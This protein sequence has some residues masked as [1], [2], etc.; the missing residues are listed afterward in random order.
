MTWSPSQQGRQFTVSVPSLGEDVLLF[1]KMTA[2][3]EL[4][5]LFKYE[6]E[7][8]SEDHDITLKEVLG[9]KITIKV[10][11]LDGEF[12]FFSGHV[13]RFTYAGTRGEYARYLTTV[14]PWLWFLTL[15]SDCRIYQGE[16]VPDI[17]KD[18]FKRHGFADYEDGLDTGK[19]RKWDYCVQY[20]ETDFDFV[21]RLME[22]EGIY[23]YFKH[24]ETRHTLVLCDGVSD[25]DVTEGYEDI[26]YHPEAD[27]RESVEYIARWSVSQQVA[28]VGIG[29]RDFDFRKPR[30]SMETTVPTFDD[31][32]ADG[33]PSGGESDLEVFDYPGEYENKDEGEAYAK[34][35]MEELEAQHKLA[36][37]RSNARGLAV[38][39]LFNLTEHPRSSENR[40]YLTISATYKLESDEFGTSD[41][42]STG[43]AFK[44]VFR[45]LDSSRTY[46]TPRTTQLPSITGPQTAI[47]VGPNGEKVWPDKYGRV[48]VQ[49]HWDRHGKSD[50]NSSCW[51]R[52]SQNWA[53]AN[54]GGM[55]IPHIGQEVVVEFL[56]GDPDRPLITGRVY[57]NDQ[58]PP[59]KL[60]DNKH[61]SILQDDYGNQLIFDATP[62]DE[63]ITLYSPHHKSGIAVGKSV[64]ISTES[65][66]GEIFA[67]SKTDILGGDLTEISGGTKTETVLLSATEA[68]VGFKSEF[69]LASSLSAFV[70][71]S[72]EY[73]YSRD[74]E[75]ADVD[76]INAAE[77]D[78]LQLVFGDAI[79]DSR[80]RATAGDHDG[81]LL[82]CSGR[83]RQ[84]VVDMGEKVLSLQIGPGTPRLHEKGTGFWGGTIRAA[85][86]IGA[87][88]HIANTISAAGW[89]SL[90]QFCNVDED[91]VDVAK[92][93]ASGTAHIVN[94]AAHI[95]ALVAVTR[96]FSKQQKPDTV[97]DEI[98]KAAKT[99][100]A[101]IELKE[102]GDIVIQCTDKAGLKADHLVFEA[103]TSVNLKV[104]STSWT[105]S[106]T[107]MNAKAR[108]L[109]LG[110]GGELAIG[111]P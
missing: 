47:V 50:E 5:R 27:K 40:E 15:R 46:R 1:H 105:L 35:R 109:K 72:I 101:K 65:D 37:G 90:G 51:V 28:P 30:A 85:A 24:E 8:L 84:S 41:K 63:H 64:A 92:M 69:A 75:Q 67:G 31:F 36:E 57:N 61:K 70:G 59:Q 45:A 6:I 19:F 108:S 22:Q 52:V 9:Q 68:F 81:K 97:K 49:F 71:S 80:G 33:L 10:E 91:G 25:H 74:F 11:R 44:C 99:A 7:L 82:L 60:P 107:S 55:H 34:L 20:R 73:K 43:P 77:K 17:I 13:S 87:A 93:S 2:K 62:G 32:L 3:E 86:G 103:G 38:G 106:K 12:R 26:R 39:S 54:W 100:K 56:E 42:G 16:T 23:Y 58:M 95:M 98:E 94:L 4:G 111:G 53:G 88:A 48:K 83:T 110:Q 76:Q 18:T 66:S 14:R 104:G 102:Q 79:I 89:F 29:L 96:L 21:S 78:W